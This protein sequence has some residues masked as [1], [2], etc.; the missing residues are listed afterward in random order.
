MEEEK[1][2]EGGGLRRFILSQIEER[3]PIPFV[4]FMDWCLYHPEYGYYRSEKTRIG[5]EGDYYTSP[6]VHPI[7][8]HLIAKQL[9]QMAEILGR[10]TFDV[11]EMGGGRGFLCKDILDGVWKNYPTFYQR[12]RYHLIETAIFQLFFD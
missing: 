4:Q 7:F 2:S 9:F 3:G 8:G 10:E 12:L 11:V 6:C 5:R 1:R